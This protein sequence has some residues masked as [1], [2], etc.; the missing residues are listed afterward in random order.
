MNIYTIALSNSEDIQTVRENI[1][2][3]NVINI[4]DITSLKQENSQITSSGI[5]CI[6]SKEGKE[7]ETFYRK[8][9]KLK[10][11]NIESI[12]CANILACFNCKN[13][14]IVN[15]FENTYL[16]KSFYNYLNKIIYES[17]TSSLFSD[18]NAV[19][20]AL[21]GISLILDTKLDKKTIN[22]V[23]KYIIQ[24]GNHPLWEI[25]GEFI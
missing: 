12:N 11:D 16:L 21:V 1:N 23:D 24:N 5:F 8:M 10:L 2:K 6:N 13:S 15:D 3:I 19:K 22:K 25:N 17:D 20:N 7:P 18:K 14:I 4:K 9:E